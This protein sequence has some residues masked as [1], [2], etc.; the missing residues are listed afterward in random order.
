MRA[1]TATLHKGPS[2]GPGRSFALGLR[3]QRRGPR[4]AG[5]TL[6]EVLIAVAILLLAIGG[7]RLSMSAFAKSELRSSAFRVA[8]AMRYLFGRARG[9]GQTYRLVLDIDENKIYAER[10][11]GVVLLKDKNQEGRATP[12]GAATPILPFDEALREVGGGLEEDVPKGA[13]VASSTD[14]GEKDDRPLGG[15]SEPKSPFSAFK[16]AGL[17]PITLSGRIRIVDAQSSRM[18]MPAQSGKVYLY[19]FPMGL[20]QAARVHL[21]AGDQ[22]FRLLLHPLT[23]RVEVTSGQDL[24]NETKSG[25][26]PFDDLSHLGQPS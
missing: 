6:V 10:A 4:T 9:S 18:V 24:P 19:F 3:R 21:A 12:S 8:G 2:R 17:R 1:R 26:N 25:R 22:Y 13:A 5:F 20:T 15:Q 7:V 14:S 16:E 23:G 11:E